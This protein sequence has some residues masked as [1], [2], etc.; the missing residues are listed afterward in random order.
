MLVSKRIAKARYLFACTMNFGKPPALRV[1]PDPCP[2]PLAGAP[3]AGLATCSFPVGACLHEFFE[4][5][6]AA[7]PDAIALS[8]GGQHVSYGELNAEANRLAHHLRALG[9][10]PETLVALCLDRSPALLTALL[11]VLKAGGAYV[12]LDPDAPADRLALIVADAAAPVLLTQTSLVEKF[13]VRA[14]TVFFLDRDLPTLATQP[15]D[16]PAPLATATAAAYVIYTSGSTGVPKGVAVTHYNVVRLFQAT[17]SWFQFGASDVWT[18]FHS[19][20]FDFSVWEIW[21]ALRYG[22]RLVIVPYD[23]ARDPLAFHRLLAS[24]RVTVLNQTPSAFRLL[25]RADAVLQDSKLSLRYVIFGGEALD[26]RSL[27]NW[28]G[29][30]DGN[31]PQLV[32]MYGITETTVHVTYRPLTRAD[33]EDPRSLIGEPIPDLTLSVHDAE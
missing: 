31:A 8:F 9:V 18:L 2:P 20:S 7:T 10:G 11:A 29:R 5:H 13:S 6:A 24:Q 16:N 3:D 25:D 26:L 28:F 30:H 12:P 4:A 32:N 23:V 22:G 17:D 21:G 15:A 33:A 14:A 27:K 19:P 1:T